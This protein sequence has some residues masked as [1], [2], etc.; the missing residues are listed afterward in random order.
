MLGPGSLR[1]ALDRVARGE[2]GAAIILEN[3]LYRRLPGPA[4]EAFFGGLDDVILIDHIEH[5]T[6]EKATLVVPAGTFAESEGTL[7]NSEGRAQRFFRVLPP[8]AGIR[9]SWRTLCEFS[10]VSGRGGLDHVRT[11]DDLIAALGAKVPE[12]AAIREAAPPAGQRVNG[13]RVARE[14]VR[15]SGRTAIHAGEHVRE[16]PPPADLDSPLAFSMEGEAGLPPGPLIPRFW[17]PGWNSV[18]ALTKY[19]T[20]PGGA[21]R[22]GDPG[23]RMIEP[24]DTAE[25]G[26]SGDGPRTEAGP[27]GGQVL[28]VPVYHIFGS[29]ELSSL[30]EG[31]ET[32]APKAA[33]LVHP[34][35]A[36]GLGIGE[37]DRVDLEAGGATLSLPA[38]ITAD[39]V[40]G[41]AGLPMLPGAGLGLDL[42]GP[43]RVVAVRKT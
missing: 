2:A 32:L 3:D 26:L 38:R 39:I 31:V 4:A 6:A 40:R 41:A 16:N 8:A 37:G 12:L 36:P 1:D 22:G 30:A 28:L 17:A 21:L 23:R 43:G 34:D 35:D 20:T 10:R 24:P 7:I 13:L 29:E 33:L 9:E 27:G 42:P 18:Q 15:S 11:L 5:G 25:P 19:Q 14:T